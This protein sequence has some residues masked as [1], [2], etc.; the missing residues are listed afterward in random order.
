MMT[1]K[2]KIKRNMCFFF[3]M[4]CV[5]G[6]SKRKIIVLKTFHMWDKVGGVNCGSKL[7]QLANCYNITRF[8]VGSLYPN[9]KI[10]SRSWYVSRVGLQ[11]F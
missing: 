6:I 9:K 3:S 2:K 4:L 8:K 7:P 5:A 11:Y 10:N 1:N